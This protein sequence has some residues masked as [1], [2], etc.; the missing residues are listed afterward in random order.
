MLLKDIKFDERVDC[1]EDGSVTLYFTAP[2]EYLSNYFYR[3]FDETDV[4]MEL[5]LE[6]PDGNLNPE[7]AKV[8]VS[9]TDAEDSD[10]DW[11]DELLDYNTIAALVMM[12]EKESSEQKAKKAETERERFLSI[13]YNAICVGQL[14]ERYSEKRLL[15]ELGCSKEEFEKIMN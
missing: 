10:Y 15:E 3:E 14:D 12:Y 13:A 11:N 9:P 4:A 7:Y 5:S 2:K 1:E 8:E 6:F